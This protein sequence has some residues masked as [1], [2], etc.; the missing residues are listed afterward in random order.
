MA[1]GVAFF[2]ALVLA[3]GVSG[4]YAEGILL[5]FEGSA[6]FN[7]ALH[8]PDTQQY[9]WGE[10]DPFDITLQVCVQLDTLFYTEDPALLTYDLY[11]TG[12]VL[13]W[14]VDDGI[15]TELYTAAGFTSG[16]TYVRPSASVL[17]RGDANG[18]QGAYTSFEL[19]AASPT[20]SDNPAYASYSD[21]AV[22]AQLSGDTYFGN[23][24][25][26]WANMETSQEVY[27]DEYNYLADS[28][29][30]EGYAFMGDLAGWQWCECGE[31]IVP[32]PTSLSIL[33]LGLGG[34]I[35]RRIRKRI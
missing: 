1:R 23:Y 20:E 24:P 33:G 34:L 17:L 19:F 9:D 10:G 7:W 2:A 27:L 13:W 21:T 31:P 32:E 4:A 22:F 16:Y 14:Q 3:F 30:V 11:G 8:D 5:T 25:F 28:S 35:A 29:Y 6:W 26:F 15:S 18:C 12:S